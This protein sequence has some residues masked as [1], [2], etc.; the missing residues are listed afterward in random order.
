[1][2]F[3]NTYVSISSPS[4]SE[5]FLFE[6]APKSPSRNCYASV[7]SSISYRNSGASK[8]MMTKFLA[9]TLEGAEGCG[10]ILSQFGLV[11]EGARVPDVMLVLVCPGGDEES[12]LLC[13]LGKSICGSG[14]AEAPAS[15]LEKGG[16]FHR[17]GH[18]YMDMCW[19]AIGESEGS[20]GPRGGT[21][22]LFGGGDT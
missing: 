14:H 4:V 21:F 13:A 7:S 9:T 17:L 19:V 1:M 8:R 6:R 15:V 11:A 5:P 3:E 2:N 22:E 20:V 16:E 10:I 12:L 18:L